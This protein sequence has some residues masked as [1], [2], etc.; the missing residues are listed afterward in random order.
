MKK[1]N[2]LNQEEYIDTDLGKQNGQQQKAVLVQMRQQERLEPGRGPEPSPEVS[3]GLVQPSCLPSPS[4][5]QEEWRLRLHGCTSYKAPTL[6]VE[7]GKTSD[8]RFEF[9]QCFYQCF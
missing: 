2:E 4:G 9:Y 8:A 3:G 6:H 1:R 7:T 5:H